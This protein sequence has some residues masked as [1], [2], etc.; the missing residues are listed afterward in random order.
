MFVTGVL[1]LWSLA[2]RSRMRRYPHLHQL[3][4]LLAWLRV[5]LALIC[6]G[7][8]AWVVLTLVV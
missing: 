3:R 4:R 5:F 6:L 1:G 8:M 7:T 2:V